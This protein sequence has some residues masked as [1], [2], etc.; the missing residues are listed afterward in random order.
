MDWGKELD[1][2]F[3]KPQIEAEKSKRSKERSSDQSGK[4]KNPINRD[5]QSAESAVSQSDMRFD[6]E[7]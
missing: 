2:K 3:Y 6:R 5:E 7:R 4:D 1:N